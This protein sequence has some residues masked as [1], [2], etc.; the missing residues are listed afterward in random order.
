MDRGIVLCEKHAWWSL[1]WK[2][3]ERKAPLSRD[4]G[5]NILSLGVR[6]LLWALETIK[7]T[8]QNTFLWLSQSWSNLSVH[9]PFE[10]PA[11]ILTRATLSST[12][13]TDLLPYRGIYIPSIPHLPGWKALTHHSGTQITNHPS[14]LSSLRPSRSLSLSG[15]ASCEMLAATDY[16]VRAMVRRC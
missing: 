15:L 8:A 1:A 16:N 2:K 13:I 6:N 3:R 5:K 11:A 14:W 7:G 12:W 10:S 4:P 9:L